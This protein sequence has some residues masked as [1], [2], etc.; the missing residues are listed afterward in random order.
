[1]ARSSQIKSKKRVAVH[2]E[3]FTAEREVKAMCD[4]VADERDRIDSRFLEPACGEGAFLA[5]VLARKLAACK[6]KYGP[7]LLRPDY[8]RAAV[9]AVMSIYGVEL[10]P[11]N[12]QACRERLFAIWDEAYTK[13][14][15]VDANAQRREI[16]K[17]V[18]SLNIL[19]GDALA[20]KQANGQPIIFA[21]WPF[22][23][24][25]QVKRRDFR[26]D[27]LIE[28]N[29]KARAGW[30]PLGLKE[31]GIGYEEARHEFIPLPLK[32]YPPIDYRRLCEHGQC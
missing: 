8:G 28:A 30:I 27:K 19:C 32:E 17:F 1:M 31:E 5:E 13:N 21:E 18:L 4:L 11:D 22:I 26:L 9:N 29:E 25:S 20:M 16:V 3:V 2:G 12:A 14:C 15:G 7:A 23:D 10:L 24:G 6:Q